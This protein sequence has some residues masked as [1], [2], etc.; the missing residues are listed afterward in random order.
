MGVIV[1]EIQRRVWVERRRGCL[2]RGGFGMRIGAGDA[3]VVGGRSGGGANE[4]GWAAAP[5]SIPKPPRLACHAGFS[6]REEGWV[7]FG[8]GTIREGAIRV[9]GGAAGRRRHRRSG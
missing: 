4:G 6:E 5:Q 8:G 2:R 3:I 1:W 9:V 7:L